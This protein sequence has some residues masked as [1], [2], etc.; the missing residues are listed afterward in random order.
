MIN[1]IYPPLFY[2]PIYNESKSVFD[3]KKIIRFEKIK[4]YIM[5]LFNSNGTNKLS[6]S[7]KL[8]MN[9]T[10]RIIFKSKYSIWEFNNIIGWIEIYL[11]GARIKAYLYLKV[12]RNPKLYG[13]HHK[14]EKR[15]KLGD[16]CL[17][18]FPED[19]I[20]DKLVTFIN[21]LK[22]HNSIKNYHI[23]SN[24]TIIQIMNMNL[25]HY[26]TNIQNNVDLLTN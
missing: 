13:Q 1:S 14:I 11:D 16:I 5:N 24:L 3:E 25:K 17:I 6:S 26:F 7:D 22:G 4:Y 18:T 10:K 8:I 19:I 9:E 20:K 12:K 23:D 21:N 2:I 15:F